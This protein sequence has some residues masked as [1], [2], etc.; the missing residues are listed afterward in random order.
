MFRF[1]LVLVWSF[2]DQVLDIKELKLE[3]QIR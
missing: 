1:R 3:L 2:K